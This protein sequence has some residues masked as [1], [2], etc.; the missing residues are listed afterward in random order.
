MLRMLPQVVE[1]WKSS[2]SAIIH[3]L[4]KWIHAHYINTTVKNHYFVPLVPWTSSYWTKISFLQMLTLHKS[5]S[6]TKQSKKQIPRGSCQSHRSSSKYH[7]MVAIIEATQKQLPTSWTF[8]YQLTL[9]VINLIL[10][11]RWINLLF[12]LNYGHSAAISRVNGLHLKP[13]PV[14]HYLNLYISTSISVISI[15][16]RTSLVIKCQYVCKINV[17]GNTK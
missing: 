7:L 3:E 12:H 11:Y 10:H 1:A 2:L 6:L 8:H 13:K 17:D 4:E 9:E 14:L 15:K 5:H 16:E